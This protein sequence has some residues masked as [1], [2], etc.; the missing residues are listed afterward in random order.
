MV[1]KLFLVL[2]GAMI[3]K[4]VSAQ[5]PISV[6]NFNTYQFSEGS[7]LGIRNREGVLLKAEYDRFGNKVKTVTAL[8]YLERLTFFIWI[9]LF[10]QLQWMK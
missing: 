3:C 4:P 8:Q 1:K 5:I 10:C 7:K 6:P 9:K 2:F